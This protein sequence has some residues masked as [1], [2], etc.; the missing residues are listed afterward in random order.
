[1]SSSLDRAVSRTLLLRVWSL[2]SGFGTV[3]LIPV[4]LEP[5]E[6]GFYFAFSSIIA[7]QIFFELGLSQVLIYRFS[8]LRQLSD[9]TGE[10]RLQVLLLASRLLYRW[11]GGLYFVA[12][13]TSG[14]F[15]FSNHAAGDLQWQAPWIV[16]TIATAVNLVHSVKLGFLEAVGAMHH[17]SVARLR[18]SILA[19]SVLFLVLACGGGLWSACVVPVANALWFSAWLQQHRHAAS[20]REERQNQTVQTTEIRTL[21]MRD[22]FPMQWKISLSWISGYFIFQL[23]TP[24]VFK[25]YGSIEAG[26]LGYVI[27]IMSTLLVVATTFTTALAPKLAALYARRQINDYNKVFD[28]SFRL[29]GAALTC[30]L[31][32]VVAASSLCQALALPIADRLLSST[33][34]LIYA[35]IATVS[36][37]TSCLSIYL[38]S[39]QQEPLLANSIVTSLALVPTLLL[40]SSSSLT[41]LLLASLAVQTASFVWAVAIYRNNRRQL[42]SSTTDRIEP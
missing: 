32:S 5:E 13:L 33:D 35:G 36:G 9:R 31:L 11:L 42:T 40:G 2:I 16:L 30:S 14:L 39:Q 27:A 22:I 20:Y 10:T 15:F 4:F 21:W 7:I 34:T 37:L 23:Y 26:K 8:D 24:I 19:T 29:S 25:R 17:V 38:R 28:R 3:V 1:M 18:A 41:R 6:Q 12:A